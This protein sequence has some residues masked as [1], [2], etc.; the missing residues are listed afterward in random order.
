MP[1][2]LLLLHLKL[3]IILPLHPVVMHREEVNKW[4]LKIRDG[5][6]KRLQRHKKAD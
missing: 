4:L 6:V 3:I 1:L 2:I 5:M